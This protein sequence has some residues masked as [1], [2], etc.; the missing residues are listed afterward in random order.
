MTLN[1]YW[2]LL[3]WLFAGG[4]LCSQFPRRRE[5]L[6]GQAVER[7]D[8]LPAILLVLPYIV[9]AGFRTEWGDTGVYRFEFMNSPV[10]FG[11]IPGI[12]AGE[13]KDKGFYAFVAV[14]K[15]II[16]NQD[17]L[18]FLFFAVVQGLCMALT[19]RRYCRDYWMCMFLFVA[20]TD[21]MS[22]MFNGMR[23]FIATTIMFAGFGLALKKKYVP[24]ICLI[25]LASTIHGS[26][27][28]MI[29]VMFIVQGKAWNGKTLLALAATAVVVVFVDQFTPILNNLLQDTQYDTMMT[30]E[31]WNQDDG[32]NI[33]RVLIYSVPALLS[34]WGLKYVRSANDPV[35]NICVNCSI[36]TMAL[37][38]IAAVS[39]GIYIGRLPIY[40]TL[41]GYIALP[42]LIDHIFEKRSADL[43]RVLT[44][45]LYVLFFYLQMNSWGML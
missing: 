1:N 39:S 21:Y 24:L 26:A 17:K 32:T 34:L 30:N 27:L 22:W 8:V 42:W 4:F 36:V 5:R 33:L 20:S 31:Y 13:G 29:P 3:I 15:M 25:L 45:V 37:Y 10:G 44:I 18:F 40:T 9:W 38:L 6:G 23:Q 28:M 19:F 43:V 41:Q 7:W 14:L 11:A 16:G 35:I 2:W 12:L